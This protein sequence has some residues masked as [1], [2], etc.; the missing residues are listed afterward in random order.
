MD[1]DADLEDLFAVDGGWTE[2]LRHQR[3]HLD[4]AALGAHPDA[5]AAL[6]PFL[7]GQLLR[8]L[9]ERFRLKCLA[10]LRKANGAIV[11]IASTRA[12]Q[13]EPN[14]EAY[15]ATKGGVVALTHAMAMSLG[16]QVRVFGGSDDIPVMATGASI[17]S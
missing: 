6:D 7:L 14:T 17:G 9:Y 5:I 11:N 1:R 8:N 15:A 2:A 4:H 12:L 13:S 16:P 3:E 10:Q